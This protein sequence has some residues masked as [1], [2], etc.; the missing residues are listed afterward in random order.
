[1]KNFGRLNN[2]IQYTE[3]KINEDTCARNHEL[4]FLKFLKIP[5]SVRANVAL[6]SPAESRRFNGEER[7]V[8]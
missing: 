4:G 5:L 1:M 6:L 2:H 7:K 8:P 3:F